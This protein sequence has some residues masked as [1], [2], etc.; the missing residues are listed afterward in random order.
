MNKFWFCELAKMHIHKVVSVFEWAPIWVVSLAR[1]LVACLRR[2]FRSRYM[3][4]QCHKT[5][6]L[7]WCVRAI[8]DAGCINMVSILFT[9]NHFQM[10]F[11]FPN[12]SYIPMIWI[13]VHWNL[14]WMQQNWYIVHG[15]CWI[16]VSTRNSK[17]FPEFPV[18]DP[19]RDPRFFRNL[20]PKEWTFYWVFFFFNI[21]I[22]NL[23]CIVYF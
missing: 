3:L 15:T 5:I 17:L 18:R 19:L 12:H 23:I 8:V 21:L 11:I 7:R 9:L 10:N 2:R 1:I 20:F 16:W 6:P 13:K 14:Y 4:L 22:T